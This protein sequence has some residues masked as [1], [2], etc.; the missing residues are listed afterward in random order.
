[1]DA[2]YAS[3]ELRD[4]PSLIG[5]P[6]V[7]GGSPRGRGE[8]VPMKDASEPEHWLVKKSTVRMLWI[9]TFVILAA[10]TL[11]D[12]VIKKKPHFDVESWFGFGSLFGFVACVTLV[13]GSKALGAFL[14][15]RDTYYDD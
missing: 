10:L 2:F 12:L 11:L 1:M 5:K 6:V 15:R 13:F 8:P 14:K 4:D 3:V 7:V 9:A